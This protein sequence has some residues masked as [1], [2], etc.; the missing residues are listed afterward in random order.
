MSTN[1]SRIA[2]IFILTEASSTDLNELVLA[3]RQRRET[4]SKDNR[5]TLK[6]GQKVKFNGAKSGLVNGTIESIKIKKATVRSEK[7]ELWNVPLTILEAA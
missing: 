4:L 2:K 6:V 5:L 1:A 3:I 7:N